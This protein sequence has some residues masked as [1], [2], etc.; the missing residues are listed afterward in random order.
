MQDITPKMAIERD[1]L[2]KLLDSV[3]RVQDQLGVLER[4]QEQLTQS[5][6]AM[7]PVDYQASVKH[8]YE[9]S[10]KLRDYMDIVTRATMDL[11]ARQPAPSTE[12]PARPEPL[13]TSP[14]D[15]P[16]HDLRQRVLRRG[17]SRDTI[18]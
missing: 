13:G 7:D 14:T 5:K 10:N 4:Y 1:A 11:L 8:A 12:S 16:R 15:S 18:Q 17:I 6:D 9:A 3:M 2:E